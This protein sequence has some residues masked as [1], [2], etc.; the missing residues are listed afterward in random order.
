M[1]LSDAL[2]VIKKRRLPNAVLHED[3]ICAKTESHNLSAC[4][5]DV[6]AVYT[7]FDATLDSPQALDNRLSQNPSLLKP[8]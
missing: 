7:K 5:F 2:F 4:L 6:S 3:H 8:Q 1:E